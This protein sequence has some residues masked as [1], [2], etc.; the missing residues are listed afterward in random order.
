MCRDSNVIALAGDINTAF[1]QH[2][3]GIYEQYPHKASFFPALIGCRN[4]TV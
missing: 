1:H 3:F 4:D 2:Q